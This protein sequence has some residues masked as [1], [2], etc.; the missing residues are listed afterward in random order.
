MST[1]SVTLVAGFV[2]QAHKSVGLAEIIFFRCFVSALL[3]GGYL[4]WQ[5]VSLLPDNKRIVWLRS[6]MATI[7]LACY[8]FTIGYI[9]FGDA[10]MLGYSYPVFVPILAAYFLSEKIRREIY[11]LIPV[12]LIGIALIIKP[13]LE[14]KNWVALIGVIG[15]LATAFDIVLIG[16]IG[17]SEP[18]LRLVFWF[19]AFG[20]AVSVGF[21]DY[22][23]SNLTGNVWYWLIGAGVLGAASQIL[24]TRGFSMGNISVSVVLVYSGVVMAF[25]MGVLFWQ[26]A[27]AMT[28]VLGSFIVILSCARILWIRL[29]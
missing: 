23:F 6:G 16:K 3:T 21:I 28:S 12:S 7:G 27:P 24:A 22:R 1:I 13:Q 26:E 15:S 10:N 29:K 18:A 5:G 4:L 8:F 25:V 19:M 9:P 20:A 2:K 17:K 11:I 14:W